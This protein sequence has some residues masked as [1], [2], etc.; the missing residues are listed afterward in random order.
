MNLSELMSR[1][2]HLISELENPKEA[3]VALVGIIN[4]AIYDIQDEGLEL[5]G[6]EL[7]KRISNQIQEF[8][9]VA[10]KNHAA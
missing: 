10:K 8:L 5:T 3:R 9:E 1:Y 2:Y 7:E 4:I 6:V